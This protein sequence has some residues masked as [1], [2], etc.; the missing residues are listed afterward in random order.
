VGMKQGIS[1][2]TNRLRAWFGTCFML[3]AL[4]REPHRDGKDMW[5]FGL[6]LLCVCVFFFFLLLPKKK[7]DDLVLNGFWV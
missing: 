2:K 7:E 5:F 6:K 1:H 4:C 3:F